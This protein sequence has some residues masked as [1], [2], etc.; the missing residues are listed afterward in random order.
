MPHSVLYVLDVEAIM[1]RELASTHPSYNN[2]CISRK[3][4][5]FMSVGLTPASTTRDEPNQPL[6]PEMELKFGVFI[7]WVMHAT[8]TDE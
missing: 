6:S 3:K 1:T 7:P 4:R 2:R 8:N 5:T